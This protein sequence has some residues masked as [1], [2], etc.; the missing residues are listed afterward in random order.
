MRISIAMGV[1]TAELVTDMR[2]AEKEVAKRMRDIEATAKRA[3]VAIGAALAGAATATAIA[4]KS[5]ID[6]ADELSKASQKIG[7]STE[8]LSAL[9][10]AARLSDVSLQQ[11][12]TGVGKLSQNMVA[13]VSGNKQLSGAFDAIGVSVTDA[14][15]KLRG[16]DDVLLDLADVFKSLPDGADQTA[17][18]MQL[19]G[20]SGRDM[21]PLLNGGSEA[22]AAMTDEAR[23]LGLVVGAEFGKQAEAFNDSLTAARAGLEGAANTVAG[24]LIP[25]LSE[26]ARVLNDQQFREGFAAI[27]EGAAKA[28]IA[29]AGLVSEIGNLARFAGEDLAARINGP[30]PDDVRR[31][32]LE[33]KDLESE[34]QRL[35]EVEQADA[36]GSGVSSEYKQGIVDRMSAIQELIKQQIILNDLGR[37]SAETSTGADEADISALEVKTAKTNDLTASL[38]EYYAQMA[39]GAAAEKAASDAA[40]EISDAKNYVAALQEQVATFGMSEAA[41]EQ[42]TLAHTTGLTPAMREAA[43]A[44]LAQ[45]DAN[46]QLEAAWS[47]AEQA[48]ASL[49]GRNSQLREQIAQQNDKL[50][51]LSVTQIAINAAKRQAVAL[52]AKLALA[53]GGLTDAMRAELQASID[54]VEQYESNEDIIAG[55]AD[56]ASELD[57][58]L[59]GLDDIGL[60][61]LRRD[62]ALVTEELEKAR[63]TSLD[64]FDPARVAELQAALGELR[65]GMVVGVV[66]SAQDGLRSLQSMASEGSDAFQALQ[67]A[68]DAL[69]LVQ[70]ISAVLNQ[71][72]G[73]PYTAFARMAAMAAAVASLGVSVGGM[74]GG[75][76]NVAQDRQ[77]AQGTGSVLGDA[78]ADSAS[79]LNATEITANATSQLVGIN[80]SMLNALTAMQAGLTG[81]STLL[82]RGAGDVDFAAPG[83]APLNFATRASLAPLNILT[84]GLLDGVLGSITRSILG[85]RSK[86]TDAGLLIGGGMLSEL[87]DGITVSAYQEVSSRSWWFG[88]THT[89]TNTQALGDDVAA[90]F[91]LVLDSMA[92]AVRAG[93]EALGLNMEEV[94]A[95]IAAYQIEEIRIS[96][97]DLSAEEA[98]AELEAVFGEIFDGLAGSVVP[99]IDQF[100]QVGEGLGETLVRVATGVMVTQEAVRQLGFA[101][102]ETDPERFAQISEGLIEMAGGIDAFISSMG[103]FVNAFAPEAHKFEVAQTALNTAF[104]EAGMVL[105]E[106]RDGMWQLMQSLDATTESGQQQIATLLRLSGT[107][108]SY[109]SMLEAEQEAR[110]KAISEYAGIVL[111]I[112]SQLSD[113]AGGSEFQRSLS[114]IAQQYN[115][116]VEALNAA[117]RAAGM[118]SAREEDLARALQLSTLQRARAVAAL[119]AEGQSL[120]QSLGYTALSGIEAQIAALEQEESAAT[121]AIQS[122][123]DAMGEAASNATDAINLLLG[124]LSPY[125]DR[126]KLQMALD[127]QQQGLIGPEEVLR[128]AQRLFA[129]GTDYNQ[130]F[131]QVM[132]IGDRR[133]SG[134]T[135]GGSFGGTAEQTVSPEMQ[136]LLAERDALIA[137]QEAA[138]RRVQAGDLSQIIADIAGA[139][140][141][142]FEEAAA[143]LG[144]ADI[145][146]L[147]ADLGIDLK[148]LNDYLLALQADSYSITDIAGTITAGEQGIIDALYDIFGEASD[149]SGLRSNLDPDAVTPISAD[150][151]LPIDPDPIVDPIIDGGDRMIESMD[152]NSEALESKIE[153]L[154]ATIAELLA[155]IA[156]N[157][158]A[159]PAI[160]S[161]TA[162]NQAVVEA[163]SPR[164]KRT[165]AW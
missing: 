147:A 135:F 114:D 24:A 49:S 48:A 71:G 120:A 20:K 58:I 26:A 73:D 149:G 77:D 12:S 124:D 139:Q 165:L 41:L 18:A 90:Q 39:E 45:I 63:D 16:A 54:L 59:R 14:N 53:K 30:S 127:A 143:Q 13:A 97:M 107:A 17:L 44:A 65:H 87:L 70:A 57:S 69:T 1:D 43:E 116:N 102:D 32:T 145:A 140:G 109:Y 31:L 158:A 5:A 163:S 155:Q 46:R 148:S 159:L 51:G 28:T 122:F 4:I 6:R 134:Q 154:T 56:A 94:N 125:K 133:S 138:S 164:S 79:I 66:E 105:P 98:Q 142:A 22:I 157:T 144:I 130:I 52:E 50:R 83:A 60:D 3:G 128:I 10:Y 101:L 106:T 132:A 85:A 76:G 36:F 141:I 15:G 81:A 72:N 88:S 19:M 42:Y 111:D 89:N 153:T 29:V 93:A 92:D 161:V 156:G 61:G 160:A 110:N 78:S 21:V 47:S 100:Q 67:I 9:E 162:A 68:I 91:Q 118:A 123:G 108:D 96:T 82:A 95:A 11:L 117:A 27:I 37:E 74:A 151:P 34:L 2:R 35:N 8:S 115:N 126:E 146:A 40:R 121:A 25:T 64:T 75:F 131:A 23:A 119:Q 103:D 38:R 129:S 152:K 104:S 62:M 84:L 150:E 80:R 55:Q 7:I 112:D 136:A 113:L 86:I 33:F 137:Q 99:F